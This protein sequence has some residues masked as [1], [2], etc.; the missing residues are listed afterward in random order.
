MRLRNTFDN[1]SILFRSK[2]I[3]TSSTEVYVATAQKNLHEERLKICTELWGK[4][5]KVR[6]LL[7]YSTSLSNQCPCLQTEH[8][9]KKNPKMLSQ[10]QHCEEAGI[11]L[12]VIVGESELQKGVVKLRCVGS[13]EEEEVPRGELAKAVKERLDKMLAAE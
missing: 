13:R 10:L 2:P 11:P 3:R 12:A 1:G 8:S 4:N 6:R 5:I 9:Y 7:E